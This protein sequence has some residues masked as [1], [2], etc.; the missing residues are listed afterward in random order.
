MDKKAFLGVMD[1]KEAEG[2]PSLFWFHFSSQATFA[3]SPGNPEHF[4]KTVSGH[5]K[6]AK[7]VPYGAVKAM[8]EGYFM[9][10]SLSGLK[11]YSS[12]SLKSV[13]RMDPHDPWIE[14]QVDLCKRIS[15]IAGR[16]SAMF[17]TLFSPLFY[18]MFRSVCGTLK[19]RFLN[20]VVDR[21]GR[22]EAINEKVLKGV[23]LGKFKKLGESGII[24]T[25]PEAFSIA[26]DALIQDLKTL[27][28][29]LLTEGGADGIFLSVQESPGIS[30]EQY[31]KLI[32]PGEKELLNL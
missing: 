23:R 1:N 31:K 6:Y 26:H 7:E 22:I 17:Y 28:K 9:P 19:N 13:K 5:E 29:R 8:T 32:A 14:E 20:P 3:A 24:G 10:S 21:L 4:R 30:A 11:D 2:V 27:S 18:L 12:A 15:A 16:E 25:D